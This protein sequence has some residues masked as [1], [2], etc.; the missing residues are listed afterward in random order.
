VTEARL[1]LSDTDTRNHAA[2]QPLSQKL[3]VFGSAATDEPR[4]FFGGEGQ[5]FDGGPPD[6]RTKNP[7]EPKRQS[8]HGRTLA[9]GGLT[10]LGQIC[11]QLDRDRQLFD[12]AQAGP[13]APADIG[14]RGRRMQLQPAHFQLNLI[15]FGPQMLHGYGAKF[16]AHRCG[17]LAQSGVNGRIKGLRISDTDGI[18]TGTFIVDR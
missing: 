2:G 14:G 15:G 4:E 11:S 18:A 9:T 13:P 16:R 3:H 8:P 10:Q 1:L 6:G 7:S 5:C 17:V 12:R